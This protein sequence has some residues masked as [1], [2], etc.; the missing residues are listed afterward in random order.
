MGARRKGR[1]GDPEHVVAA[2]RVDT[3]PDR[4]GGLRAS[5]LSDDPRIAGDRRR[6]LAAQAGRDACNALLRHRP[7]RTSKELVRQVS[8]LVQQITEA[9]VRSLQEQRAFEL[10]V[11]SLNAIAALE[12]LGNDRLAPA[13]ARPLDAAFDI[14]GGVER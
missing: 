4:G 8:Q 3:R 10:E 7:A 9:H 12:G 13:D 1:G 14:A 5:S 6:W 11:A 2:G